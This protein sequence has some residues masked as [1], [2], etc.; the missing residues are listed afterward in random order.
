[1]CSLKLCYREA[2]HALRIPSVT[3][4]VAELCASAP[5]APYFSH[6]RNCICA[7]CLIGGLLTFAAGRPSSIVPRCAAVGLAAHHRPRSDGSSQLRPITH[8]ATHRAYRPSP[9]ARALSSHQDLSIGL[10]RP[11]ASALC[12]SLGTDAPSSPLGHLLLCGSRI[13]AIL[14]CGRPCLARSCSHRSPSSVSNQCGRRR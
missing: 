11:R 8:P 14:A 10:Y 13:G 4:W 9:G 6:R 7:A 12:S 3:A 1:M 2:G 5:V